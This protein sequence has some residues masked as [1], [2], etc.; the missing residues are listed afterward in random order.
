MAPKRTVTRGGKPKSQESKKLSQLDRTASKHQGDSDKEDRN[1]NQV[2]RKRVPISRAQKPDQTPSLTL[3]ND[4]DLTKSS[5]TVKATRSK[6]SAAPSPEKIPETQQEPIA[7]SEALDYGDELLSSSDDEWDY[8]A[9]WN[10][11]EQE[12]KDERIAQAE[13]RREIL[14]LR[15]IYIA[16]EAFQEARDLEMKIK[17]LKEKIAPKELPEQL[18]RLKQEFQAYKR[19]KRLSDGAR[20]IDVLLGHASNMNFALYV[21]MQDFTPDHPSTDPVGILNLYQSIQKTRQ[22]M[23]QAAKHA[24]DIATNLYLEHH[25]AMADYFLA[26]KSMMDGDLQNAE[27]KLSKI[28]Q[29]KNSPEGRAAGEIIR[30]GVAVYDA[31]RGFLRYRAYRDRDDVEDET[32]PPP[33][34]RRQ[35]R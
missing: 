6:R 5:A 22:G 34:P 32:P 3:S 10:P 21:Y 17:D 31:G 11:K 19:Q 29:D 12:R 20:A 23:T 30:M 15:R 2:K 16:N 27:T 9:R 26:L 18:R 4:S 25:E 1:A 14:R 24:K 8:I 33:G 7:A 35:T 28:A 13:R